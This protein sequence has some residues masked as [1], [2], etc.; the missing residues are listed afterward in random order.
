ME[1]QSHGQ[2]C[3]AAAEP[4]MRLLRHDLRADLLRLGV[5]KKAGINGFIGVR[6]E[7]TNQLRTDVGGNVCDVLIVVDEEVEEIG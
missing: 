5:I 4:G 2:T 1:V 3:P 6:D 7:G